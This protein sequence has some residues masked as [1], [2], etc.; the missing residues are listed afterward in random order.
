M[1]IGRCTLAM[2]DDCTPGDT[3]E[4]AVVVRECYR[5][6]RR[7]KPYR[8]CASCW[9]IVRDLMTPENAFGR[10]VTLT[11]IDDGARSIEEGEE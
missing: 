5:S 7:Q 11:F 8:A 2:A 10:K 1:D 4:A 3:N 9:P 6:G